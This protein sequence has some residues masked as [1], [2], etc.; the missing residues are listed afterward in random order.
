LERAQ[1]LNPQPPEG[2][3]SQFLIGVIYLSNQCNHKNSNF[4]SWAIITYG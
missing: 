1:S 3:S 4:V 2:G